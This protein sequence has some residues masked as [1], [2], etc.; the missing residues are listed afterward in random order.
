M[1][2]NKYKVVFMGTG[3]F[4]GPILEWLIPRYEVLAVV[5]KPDP[6]IHD[7][8]KDIAQ[9]NELKLFQPAK[10]KDIYDELEELNPDFILVASYGK[11][12]SQAVLDIPKIAPLNVHGSVLPNLRGASPVEFA[13]LEGLTETGISLMVMDAGMDTGPVIASKTVNVDEGETRDSLRRKLI[14]ASRILL[15]E[16]LGDFLDGKIKPQKQNDEEAT[17]TKLL[18]RDDGK[19]DWNKPA[20]EIE[21]QIRAFDPWPG[22]FTD[23][24]GKMLKILKAEPTEGDFKPGHIYKEGNLIIGCGVGTGLVVDE[25]QLEGKN[26]TD[27]RSFL[28]GHQ[29]FLK[30]KLK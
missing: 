17:Y 14:N 10:L 4:A 11:I 25:I 5:T 22:T 18:T 20:I 21:R 13:I 6:N 3:P 23:W 2:E 19:V 27:G 28:N 30:A 1:S 29:D 16:K 9:K 8:V 15:T 7:Q 12:I 24:K 26:K